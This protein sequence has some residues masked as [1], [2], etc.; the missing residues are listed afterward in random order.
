MWVTGITISSHSVKPH[1][2][3]LVSS[4]YPLPTGFDHTRK[5]HQL[6]KP[7]NYTETL[8]LTAKALVEKP[9]LFSMPTS[10]KQQSKSTANTASSS[11]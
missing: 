10:I 5:Q 6:A 4:S 2:L 3:A 7:S 11:A 1:R 8:Y 9:G